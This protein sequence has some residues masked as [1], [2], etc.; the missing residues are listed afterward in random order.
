MREASSVG[1]A[2][3][4]I[5]TVTVGATALD[6]RNTMDGKVTCE[7]SVTCATVTAIEW[8]AYVSRTVSAA[9]IQLFNARLPMEG[10][11]TGT[12]TQAL[13]LD[14]SGYRYLRIIASTVTGGATG[15]TDSVAV[16][17]CYND[18]MASAS[19][20]GVLRLE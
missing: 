14:A 12:R 3:G 20:D 4:S 16:T 19:A 13:S 10:S 6:L 2:A 11:V 17:Y 7:L 5:A 1:R 8:Y 18:Y 9:D 15:A